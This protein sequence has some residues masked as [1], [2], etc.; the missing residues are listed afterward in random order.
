[1]KNEEK[2]V[3]ESKGRGRIRIVNVQGEAGGSKNAGFDNK[4]MCK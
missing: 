4:A 2:S 3:S 1:M